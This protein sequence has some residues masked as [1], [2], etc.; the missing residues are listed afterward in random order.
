[1]ALGGDL[2][3]VQGGL[4][5]VTGGGGEWSPTARRRVRAA[6]AGVVCP[7]GARSHC[8]AK[9]LSGTRAPLSLVP[10]IATG[11]RNRT[12]SAMSSVRSD[13]SRHSRRK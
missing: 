13:A 12:S 2:G 9:N 11:S 3:A 1:M 8:T 5:R 10:S 7:P 6:S 4:E